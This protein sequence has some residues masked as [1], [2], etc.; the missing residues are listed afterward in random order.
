MTFISLCKSGCHTANNIPTPGHIYLIKCPTDIFARPYYKVWHSL[1]PTWAHPGCAFS[2]S[3]GLK[4]TLIYDPRGVVCLPINGC[5]RQTQPT[6]WAS[7]WHLPA[8]VVPNA[9]LHR[10]LGCIT[11]SIHV[12]V[13][14]LH[15]IKI[16]LLIYTY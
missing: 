2:L 8:F 6:P 15:F 11:I 3:R 10:S 14:A 7:Q 4:Q 12:L 13:A 16:W 9:V 1:A 5:V